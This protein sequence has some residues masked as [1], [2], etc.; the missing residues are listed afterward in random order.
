MLGFNLNICSL[1]QHIRHTSKEKGLCGVPGII[2]REL[3]ALLFSHVCSAV[4][5]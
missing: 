2:L 1:G 5:V 3:N 4:T